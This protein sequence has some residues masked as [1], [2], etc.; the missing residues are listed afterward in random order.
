MI[1]IGYMIQRIIFYMQ[2]PEQL[3]PE[4]SDV[5]QAVE[6]EKMRKAVSDFCD[7]KREILTEYQN[8]AAEV[9][10]LELAKQIIKDQQRG[11]EQ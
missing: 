2:N 3:L 7:A 6:I 1:D 9:V 11:I 10:C 4:A 8:L 5:K